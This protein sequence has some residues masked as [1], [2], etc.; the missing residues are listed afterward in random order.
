MQAA[1]HSFITLS[2]HVLAVSLYFCPFLMTSIPYFFICVLLFQN[3][4]L[5]LSD[6]FIQKHFMD[7]II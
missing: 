4:S 6:L 2:L 7:E 5:L 3:G 1:H